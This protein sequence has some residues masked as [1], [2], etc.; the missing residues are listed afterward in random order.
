MLRKG[1]LV[2]GFLL[3]SVG[4]AAAAPGITT[5]SLKLRVGP[6]TGYG[7]LATMPAGSAVNVLG[8]GPDGW[9]RVMFAS[10][11]GYANGKYM[12]I[13]SGYPVAGGPVLVA[14][15][16]IVV[17]PAPFIVRRSYPYYLGPHRHWRSRAGWRRW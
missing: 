17:A 15:A 9:C 13:G 5:A 10:L 3:I 12:N 7:V 4:L 14:P 8:C 11:T 2:A 6:G 16:P 1:M